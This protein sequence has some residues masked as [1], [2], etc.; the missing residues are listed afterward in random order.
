MMSHDPFQLDD[1]NLAFGD[2]TA[3]FLAELRPDTNAVLGVAGP[4]AAEA[5]RTLWR[6]GFKRSRLAHFQR[7]PG[8]PPFDALLVTGARR[9]QQ[10]TVIV[11]ST[12]VSMSAGAKLGVD[13]AAMPPQT[14]AAMLLDDL[15]DLGFIDGG[16]SLPS[17]LAMAQLRPEQDG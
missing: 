5:L 7:E 4:A 3:L 1:P 12:L 9:A 11:A 17:F 15:G 8:K 2:A 13:L 10:A 6:R 14:D 16:S